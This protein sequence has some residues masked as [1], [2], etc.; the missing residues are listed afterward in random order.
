[1][2]SLQLKG[3]LLAPDTQTARVTV[4]ER[5]LPSTGQCART[6][7]VFIIIYKIVKCARPLS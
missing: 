2:T 4:Q 7:D 3:G 1:M 5:I 6:V